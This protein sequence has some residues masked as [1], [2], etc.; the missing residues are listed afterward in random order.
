MFKFFKDLIN[1]LKPIQ[2]LNVTFD[3][4]G[5]NKPTIVL[6]HGIAATSKT[7]NLLIK[8]MDTEKYRLIVLDLLGF[9]D[10]P[11]PARCKYDVD[12]H[13]RYIRK[14][15]KRLGIFHID[16]LVG[17]SMGSIISARYAHY[18]PNEVDRLYLLSLPLYLDKGHTQT[19]ISRRRT[20]IYLN[21]YD[22][23]SSRKQFTIT[24]SK[25]LRNILRPIDGGEVTEEN[26]S[27]F[28]LSLKN[29]IINQDTYYDICSLTKPIYVIYGIFDEVL[30]PE[31]LDKLAVLEN[32][33]IVKLKNVNH[34]IGRNYAKE[35]AKIIIGS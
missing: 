26:W 34:M 2:S 20:D 4:G 24:A 11:K 17:H 10:S 19:L 9:G 12:D 28:R 5:I 30:V 21:I 35:V 31:S 32:V 25:H 1:I 8:D 22:F 3:S 14:T 29:T 18:H 15:L 7:W 33:K 16:K 27:A 6:L 13:I 23:I